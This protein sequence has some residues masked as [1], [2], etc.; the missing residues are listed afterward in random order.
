MEMSM[1]GTR[2]TFYPWKSDVPLNSG[3]GRWWNFLSS[4]GRGS[5][6]FNLLLQLQLEWWLFLEGS[7]ISRYLTPTSLILPYKLTLHLIFHMK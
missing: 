3:G 1:R 4:H 6:V 2:F 5:Y 7:G